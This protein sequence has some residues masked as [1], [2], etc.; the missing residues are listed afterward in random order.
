MIHLKIGDPLILVWFKVVDNVAVDILLYKSLDEKYFM[1]TS[2]V[3]CKFLPFNSHLAAVLQPPGQLSN[4]V[5]A[6]GTFVEEFAR[7]DEE[8]SLIR[9]ALQVLVYAGASSTVLK[10]SQRPGSKVRSMTQCFTH[11][12]LIAMREGVQSSHSVSVILHL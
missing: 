7:N 4:D 1:Y 6:T 11:E 2:T 10:H 12:Q 9:V 8:R 5:T 3:E